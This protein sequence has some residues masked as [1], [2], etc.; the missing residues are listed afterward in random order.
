[1]VGGANGLSLA[2]AI[3]PVGE[4]FRLEQDRAPIQSL[5]TMG[6]TARVR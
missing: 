4:V 3:K 5:P 1:M 6:K 2:N